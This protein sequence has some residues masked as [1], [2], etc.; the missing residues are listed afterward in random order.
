MSSMPFGRSRGDSKSAKTTYVTLS[1]PP[2]PIPWIVLP[3]RSAAMLGAAPHT[4]VP[5]ANMINAAIAMA[6]R[7]ST[8]HK[9]AKHGW[10][11]AEARRN[12]VPVQ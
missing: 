9:V 6:L 8:P 4:I 12:E 7:P 11:T 1:R 2:P 10:N 5:I 3:A